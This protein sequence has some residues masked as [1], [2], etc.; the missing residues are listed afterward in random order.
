MSCDAHCGHNVRNDLYARGDHNGD[1]R[2]GRNRDNGNMD[3]YSRRKS[4]STAN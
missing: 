3:N 2:N 1:S 4:P